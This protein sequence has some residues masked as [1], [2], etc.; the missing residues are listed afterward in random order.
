MI[1]RRSWQLSGLGLGLALATVGHAAD[2]PAPRTRVSY[3]EAYG[4]TGAQ[5]ELTTNDMPRFAAVPADKALETFQIKRGF[6]L[7]LAAA[8]PRVAS[9]VTLAFDEDNRMYVAE[10]IDY[11]ERRDET[12]HPGRI[13]RL[14]DRDGDGVF[15]TSTVFAENLPWPTALICSKGGIFVGATPDILWLKDNDGDG[16]ADDRAVV[17]RGF[18]SGIARLNVQALLNSFNWGLD[19]RIHGATG[20]NGG[21]RVESVS[22]TQEPPLDLRGLDFS[23]DPLSMR[24]RPELGGGQYGLSFDSTGRKFVCS[25]S[26][27]LQMILFDAREIARNPAFAMPSPRISI[28]A[29]GPAAEVFRISPDEPWRIV[30]TRWRISGVVPGMV[31]GGGRVSG[32][33]TGATGATIYRGDAYGPEF[34]DNAFIGD[35][36]G[37]L[38][39][40][41][42]MEPDGIGLVA[43]RPADEQGVEFLASKDTWFR[44][45]HFQNGPDGCLYVAD[46]YREVIEHPWSIPEAIK[47]HV[48]LNS[49]NDRGR[50]WRIV[51]EGFKRP[52][53]AKLSKLSGEELARLLKSP[54]GWTR[55]TASRLIY[56]RQDGSAANALES[57]LVDASSAL[58]RIHALYALSGL[59]RLEGVRHLVPALSD[60]DP[61]V[62]E[63]AVRL[64]EELIGRGAVPQALADGLFK[65]V[66]DENNRVRCQLALALGGLKD[67]RRVGALAELARRA[68]GNAW[69]QA[70]ILASLPEGAGEVFAE[71]ARTPEFAGTTGGAEF[72][73]RLA[74]V[75]GVQHREADVA[76][77]LDYA[78]R[79][80]VQPASMSVVRSLVD[81]A[82]RA[83]M[84][85][86]VLDRRGKLD[87]VV[88]RARHLAEEPSVTES[89]R[90]E[91]IQ[92]LG[93]TSHAESGAVLVRLLQAPLDSVRAAALASL[94]RFAAPEV[95]TD[96]LRAWKQ[97][98]ARAKVDAVSVLVT[99]ADRSLALLKAVESGTVARS[100]VPSAAVQSLRQNKDGAVSALATKLFPPEPAPADVLKTFQPALGMAGDATKGKAIYLERCASC[101][102]A[103]TDGYPLGP[104]FVTVKAGG[105]E[106]LLTSIVQPNAEVAPQYIAFQVETRDDENYSAIIAN[107]TTLHVTLRMAN[108]Q[109]VTLPRSKV[110]GMKSSGQSLMPEGLVAGLSVQSVADLL[111]FVVQAEPPKTGK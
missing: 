111:E 57:V 91:A 54:N 53:P 33:F 67:S 56:E 13:R 17:F 66:N 46:M 9:P 48:D 93:T 16:K 51:P 107:E 44:P 27:H 97:L 65:R 7:E 100:E 4:K 84:S 72:L 108:G 74:D 35:A 87:R 99:R 36:G 55:E 109:E 47:K 75:I 32:Y 22:A 37:N 59:G 5:P 28:A 61:R 94:G 25:N 78:G 71:L 105:K 49:G 3:S 64:S 45:V 6:R 88:E 8:E 77:V 19:N 41:K 15:E 86:A 12:P 92:L 90:V 60:A 14:E 18:G 26:D 80:E 63:R 29:D 81:G 73:R 103:G 96:L 101:H 79:G 34:V 23:F 62:R 76:V 89:T 1:I 69:V 43:R 83:G 106:K 68:E 95:A 42:V 110:K 40:R 82:A 11:S 52:A 21:N 2:A 102:R 31:E 38:V 58:G 30:R 85:R 98:S 104:D 39:H 70:A 20:P 50:I 10:M 24:M